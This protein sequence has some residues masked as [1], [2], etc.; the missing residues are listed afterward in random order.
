MELSHQT[1]TTPEVTPKDRIIHG[2][3]TL[4]D[5]LMDKP[6]S[7]LDDQRQAIAALHNAS[8]TWVN[9]NEKPDPAVPILK[10]TPAQTRRAMKVLER[11]LNQ[12]PITRQPTPKGPN[13]PALCEPYPRRKTQ[14]HLPTQYP[15]VQPKETPPAVQPVARHTRS[16]TQNSQPPIALRTWSYFQQALTVTPSQESQR[17]PPKSLIAL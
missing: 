5:P 16:H 7:Q 17:Y 15:R 12:P 8:N 9:P 10:P 14:Q 4:K 11:K 2:L 3:N 1:T 6:T 13:K